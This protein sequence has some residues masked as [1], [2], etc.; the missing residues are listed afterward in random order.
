[1][2]NNRSFLIVS[3]IAVAILF[4][5]YTFWPFGRAP[6]TIV[7]TPEVDSATLI[8]SHNLVKGAASAKVT[9]VEFLDPE[10]EACRAMHPIIKNLMFEYE[11]KVK[12]VLR[13][14][15]LHG[16]SKLAA[17][18]LEEA[19][20]QDKFDSALDAVFEKQPEWADHG[21]PRPELLPKILSEVGVDLSKLDTQ[22][23]MAKH[24]WKVEQDQTDGEAVGAR[25]TPTFIV[26]GKILSE[27]GYRPSKKAVD[28]ELKK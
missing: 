8:K 3:V 12:L 7:S 18:M 16:N 23:L 5:G 2:K 26:N 1:M 19:R 22:Q 17:V 11:G 28:E 20:A 14:M 13:Y 25:R 24:G 6:E 27:I 9:I 4:L 15:P 10:C 21:R